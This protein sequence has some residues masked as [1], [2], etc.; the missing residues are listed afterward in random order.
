MEKTKGFRRSSG[1]PNWYDI[2]KRKLH[3]GMKHLGI[4]KKEFKIKRFTD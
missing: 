2:E 3:N 4:G 1:P